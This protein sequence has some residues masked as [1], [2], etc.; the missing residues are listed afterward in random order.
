MPENT[1]ASLRLLPALQQN[2]DSL[3]F[4]QMTPVQQQ[5]LPLILA[6]ENVVAQASTGSGKTAAF[7]LG[8]LQQLQPQLLSPQ[9]LV[10]CPTRE[11]ADQ[12][13]NEFRRLARTL[14]NIKVLTLCGGRPVAVQANSLAHGA[15]IVVGTPGRVEDHLRRESLATETIGCLVLDEADRMLD[16]GFLPSVQSIV[17]SLSA[18]SKLQTLLFSATY[19]E[20]IEALAASIMP[21]AVRVQVDSTSSAPD[22]EEL[23]YNIGTDSN[24]QRALETL[25]RH[26]QPETALVFCS[27]RADV[28]EVCGRLNH[29]GISA[30]G[31]HGDMEQRE[32]DLTMIRFV[33]GSARVLV[34]TDLAARGLDVTG[35]DLVV[36][37]HPARDPA[38]YTHRIGR[39]GRAGARGRACTLTTDPGVGL[40]LPTASKVKQPLAAK[41]VT[42]LIDAGKRDKIRPGDVVG[43]LTA[44]GR[45]TAEQLG[46]I[47]LMPQYCCVAV[48]H[49][50]N[51]RAL[52]I[53]QEQKLK[54]K[55]VRCRILD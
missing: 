14:P 26:Y 23:S 4:T 31:L 11:L 2:L 22:I 38:T 37:Y 52:E 12:V 28:D 42:L 25:L 55:R 20:N 54:G 5:C 35:L 50:Q 7:A 47:S 43:A 39:T 13:A 24:R 32:R 36:N 19:E 10:L 34:A 49:E 46:K 45:I 27:T 29:S 44:D 6:G 48:V 33:N 3:S 16:M 9:A 41:N 17:A 21:N 30:L 8:I 40:E 1:F 15:H 53:L 51:K 18:G